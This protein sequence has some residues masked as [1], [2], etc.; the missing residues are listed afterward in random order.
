MRESPPQTRRSVSPH[1]CRIGEFITPVQVDRIKSGNKSGNAW[2]ADM[3][4]LTPVHR[5]RPSGKPGR[6]PLPHAAALPDL[7]PV[8]SRPSTTAPSAGREPGS[9]T[10]PWPCAS[11]APSAG[12][13]NRIASRARSLENSEGTLTPVNPQNLRP[14]RPGQ[15]GNRVAGP[16]AWRVVFPFSQRRPGPFPLA[17]PP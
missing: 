1:L 10:A 7:A 14:W 8:R 15:S 3:E 12:S 4:P 16:E 13:R 17:E 5:A 11:P 9:R 2:K 6:Q